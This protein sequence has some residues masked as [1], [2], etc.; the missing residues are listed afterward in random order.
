MRTALITEGE[1]QQRA[2]N[3]LLQKLNVV[4]EG[5]KKIF[6]NGVVPSYSHDVKP[7]YLD[8]VFYSRFGTHEV[9]SEIFGVKFLTPERYPLLISS[10]KA[11]KQVPEFLEVTPSKAKLLEFY[12]YFRENFVTPK[13]I[14]KAKALYKSS[15]SYKFYPILHFPTQEYI[16]LHPNAALVSGPGS[17]AMGE[18]RSVQLHGMWASPYALWVKYALEVKGIEFE[19][20]EEDLGNKSELL[21]Q[22]NPAYKKVPVLVHNGLP[23]AESII[24]LEYIDETWADPPHLLPKDPFLRAK[25][26]FWA[27]YFQLVFQTMQKTLLTEGEAHEDVKKELLKKLDVVEQESLRYPLLFSW[28]EAIDENFEVKEVRPS[29]TKLLEFLKAMHQKH[30]PA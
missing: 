18:E 14:D 27:T 24:I 10:I 17:E 23:I 13:D 28:V 3:E 16:A 21:L 4:E 1:T 7:G 30:F 12:Q 19:Y 6:P 11:L 26:R 20:K 9:A 22:Y 15:L 8:I 5:M 29:K 25:Y 2:L